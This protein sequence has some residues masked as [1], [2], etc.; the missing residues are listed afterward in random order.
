MKYILGF[1]LLVLAFFLISH[2]M[3]RKRYKDIDRLEEWKLSIMNRPVLEELTKVKQLNMTGET[4]ELFERWRNDWDEI[5]TVNLPDVE[6]LLFDAEEY[7]DKY[8][9]RRSQE[10]QKE[11]KD[12]LSAIEKDIEKIIEELNELVGNEEK[13][14]VEIEEERD[15]FREIKKQL[16]AHRHTYGAAANRLEQLLEETESTFTLYSDATENGNY[17]EAR[18]H[19][20]KIKDNLK[21]VRSKMDKIPELLAEINISAPNQIAELKDGYK[22]MVEQGYIL[23]HVN[24]DKEMEQIE[25]QLAVYKEYIAAAEVEEA[26]LG[27]NELKGSLSALYDVFEK[28]VDARVYFAGNKDVLQDKL[29]S[30]SFENDRLKTE[31]AAV[32][33]SYHISESEVKGQKEIDKRLSSIS[34]QYELLK[35]KIAGHEIAFSFLSDSLKELEQQLEDTR[36]EH[37]V[38]AK[39]IRELRQE[40]NE[41]RAKIK[42]LSLQMQQSAKWL[43]KHN[44][45]GV[46]EEYTS[47]LEVAQEALQETAAKLEEKPLDMDSVH[48]YLEKAAASVEI[49]SGQTKQLIE[50]MLLTEKVIQYANRYRSRYPALQAALQE[51]EENFRNYEYGAALEGAAAALEDVEPGSIK[52]MKVQLEYEQAN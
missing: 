41:A 5:V 20:L 18:E 30:L 48:L 24:F 8:R 23:S 45:P 15:R 43:M 33:S 19:V 2:F 49:F 29:S 44:V 38:L 6:E 14:R 1:I 25:K 52:E 3:K 10:V 51:A 42:A 46:P 47:Q 37:N 40:E 36:S 39:K 50:Q 31:I 4:E 12:R 26:E 28:E 16:L 11:I 13:N 21:D 17:M 34:T 32:Q 9:F 7:I 27:M 22:E 35:G